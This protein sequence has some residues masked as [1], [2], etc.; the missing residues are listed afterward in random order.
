[1]RKSVAMIMA[2]GRGRRMDVLCHARPKPVLPFA[3]SFKVIDFTLSNCIHSEIDDIS[4]LVDYQ[5]SQMAKYVRQWSLTNTID[6]L[7]VLEPE[8]GSFYGTADAVYRNISYLDKSG[9]ENILILSGDHIYRMD[10]R[11][12]LAHHERTGADVTVGVIR[13]PIEEANRFGTVMTGNDGEIIKFVEK[14][15]RPP[16]NLASM[17]IYVFNREILAQRLEEDARQPD[18]PH[19]FGYSILPGMVGKD[20]VSAFEFIGYWQDIGT[21]RAYYNA[22]MELIDATTPVNLNTTRPILTGYR[23]FPPAEISRHASVENSLVSPGCVIRGHVENSI[24][25]PG[26]WVDEHAEVRNS[27]LMENVFVGYRSVVDKCIIDAETNIRKL[28]HVGTVEAS[29]PGDE[30]ITI[31]RKGIAVPSHTTIDHRGWVLPYMD[32]SGSSGRLVAMGV[33]N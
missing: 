9:A 17:G 18:S 20:K 19:D 8:T 27:V 2:G 14:S 16:S 15:S 4:M 7:H 26:V 6:K 10:Y 33:N 25:S 12:M 11:E 23:A 31:L 13:V 22:S 28:C 32:F 30:D 21:P 24:L 1:M 3:G 5:R 29:L